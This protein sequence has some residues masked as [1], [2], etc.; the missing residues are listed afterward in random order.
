M[1]SNVKPQMYKGQVAM[2]IIA[3]VFFVMGIIA[4]A[5]LVG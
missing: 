1:E 3:L 5:C 2:M 4:G